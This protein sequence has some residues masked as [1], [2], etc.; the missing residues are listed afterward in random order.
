[1]LVAD[2]GIKKIL[3]L[4]VLNVFLICMVVGYFAKYRRKER[5][6]FLYVLVLD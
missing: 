1:V 4:T 6:M 3:G 2:K 5:G